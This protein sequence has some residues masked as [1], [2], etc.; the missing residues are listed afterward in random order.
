MSD[1]IWTSF[2]VGATDVEWEPASYN[3]KWEDGR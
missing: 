1:V 3:V 2:K